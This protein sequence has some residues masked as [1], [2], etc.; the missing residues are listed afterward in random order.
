MAAALLSVL[1]LPATARAQFIDTVVAPE[2]FSLPCTV[3]G[4]LAPVVLDYC[5]HRTE[6]EGFILKSELGDAGLS[7]GLAGDDD[8]VVTTVD[9]GSPAAL[10]GVQAG[11]ALVSVD[12]KPARMSPADVAE[13]MSFGARGE[14]VSLTIERGGQTLTRAFNRDAAPV[15]AN[16][17]R[18]PN[19]L[20]GIHPIVNWRGVFIPCMG[21]GYLGPVVIA[22]CQSAYHKYGYVKASELGSTGL[23]F[24]VARPDAALISAVEPGSAAATAGIAAG[25]LL[26][27]VDG[28]PLASSAG[29]H[30][31]EL[32]FGR[33]GEA[34]HIV[35]RRAGRDVRLDLVLAARSRK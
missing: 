2:G 10:A 29:E 23:M 9:P 24:A 13:A 16:A 3:I 19:I 6:A 17:P 1:V 15:P 7:L 18:S 12:G 14:A 20:V 26:I 32:L 31:G 8:G 27:A 11:D 28:K 30:A 21:A 25:D 34:R 33:A 4:P 22:T 5:V 35:V